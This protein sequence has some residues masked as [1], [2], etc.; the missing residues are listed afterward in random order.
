MTLDAALSAMS[1]GRIRDAKTVVLL[2]H[3]ALARR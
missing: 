3:A 2:Q 1:T